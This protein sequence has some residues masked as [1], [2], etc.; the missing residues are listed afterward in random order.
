MADHA[1]G[2]GAPCR[3][4]T[5]AAEARGGEGGGHMG[6]FGGGHHLGSV[7]FQHHAMRRLGGFRRGFG[8]LS[9]DYDL[10]GDDDCYHIYHRR[11]NYR[12]GTSCG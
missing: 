11:P 1:I 6:G 12:R 4:L 3:Q 10:Y 9:N 8:S 5:G 7:G 2:N